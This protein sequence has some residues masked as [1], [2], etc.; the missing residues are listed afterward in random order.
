MKS[1]MIIRAS[2]V[3]EPIGVGSRG[4]LKGPWW[5]PGATPR[6]GSRGGSPPKP[7]GFYSVKPL[8]EAIVNYI[9]YI[10]AVFYNGLKRGF[11]K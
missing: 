9:K 7:E 2:E 6:W 11:T 10:I 8:W 4:P 3:S 5:G 1:G